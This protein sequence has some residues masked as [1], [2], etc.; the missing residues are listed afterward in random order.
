MRPL[1]GALVGIGILAAMGSLVAAQL[2]PPAITLAGGQFFRV[3]LGQVLGLPG[4]LQANASRL[5]LLEPGFPGAPDFLEL[6]FL[7]GAGARPLLFGTAPS[8]ALQL[9]LQLALA[10]PSQALSLFPFTVTVLPAGTAPASPLLPFQSPPCCLF[11]HSWLW[12]AL[13]GLSWCR[14]GGPWGGA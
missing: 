3:N 5:R 9:N 8:Q 4:T 13:G 14:G 10:Q 11:F 6:L 2:P 12:V 7:S 1:R